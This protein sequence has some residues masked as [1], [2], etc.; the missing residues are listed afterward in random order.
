MLNSAQ[1]S[2]KEY[3][4]YPTF[5]PISMLFLFSPPQGIFWREKS[6]L[7]SSCVHSAPKPLYLAATPI[8]PPKR[9]DHAHQGPHHVIHVLCPSPTPFCPS[10]TWP[11]GSTGHTWHV[12]PPPQWSS[13]LLYFMTPLSL[14]SY[15]PLRLFL[16]V[17][18]IPKVLV[19]LRLLCRVL[20]SSYYVQASWK[21]P[22]I[23]MLFIWVVC[24]WLLCGIRLTGLIPGFTISHWFCNLGKSLDSCKPHFPQLHEKKNSIYLIGLL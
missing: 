21:I 16:H 9:S 12:P 3:S 8:I 2:L 24:R 5:S 4:L 7:S 14:I 15:L 20:F 19:G 18:P 1:N 11:L 23:L 6:P 13:L 10:L 22:F 17:L